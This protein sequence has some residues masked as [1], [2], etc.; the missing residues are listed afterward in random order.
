V[1]VVIRI[2]QLSKVYHLGEIS[3]RML[4]HD[5]RRKLA[6]APEEDDPELFWALHDVSFDIRDGEVVG[7]LGRNGA[8]K[9]TL[10]KILSRITS[11]TR[12]TVKIKGR[13][14]ALLEV[15]TGFHF[16]LTGRDNVYL[17]GTILGMSRREVARKFD[18]IVAF[19]GVEGFIDTPVKR[20]SVGMRVRLAFAVAAHLEPEILLI[21]E[22]LAVGDAAF[23]QKCL[24]KIGEVSRSGRTVIFVSHSAAA[25]ESLCTRGVVLERGRVVFDGTQSAAIDAYAESRTVGTND[26]GVRTDRSG[27]GEVRVTRLELRSAVG[28]PLAIARA[29]APVEIALHFERR[30]ARNFAGLAVQVTATTHLGA[31]VFTQANWLNST[32]FDE[33]PER[34]VFICRIP[35]LPLPPGHFH[36]G[37][38]VAAGEREQHGIFDEMDLAGE[39]HVE[40]GDFFGT[41]KLPPPKAGVCLVDGDWRLESVAEAALAS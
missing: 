23:Q 39:L 17:N 12:G 29:G 9:S 10:L 33:L 18:E 16:D 20:Y 25:V 27:S 3:R 26:L 4:W 11:P 8:G 38:R 14:A 32:A 2:E 24:G 13:I 28:Q 34:G 22:V 7:L 19:S 35:R 40:A 6:H 30:S 15:G 41:G 31:A 36:L 1:S 21:D 5:W 37:F